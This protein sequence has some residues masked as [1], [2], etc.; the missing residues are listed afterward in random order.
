MGA[1]YQAVDENLGIT[2]AVKENLFLTEEFSRQFQHETN[3]LAGLKH[4][5]LPRVVDYISIPDQ[6]QYLIMDYIE[7]ED[8]RQRIERLKNIPEREVLLIGV[9]ICDALTYLHTRT[10]PVIHRDIKP[11]NIK[12][13]PQGL[14][15]LVDFGLAK[16]MIASQQTNTG[17]RA[18]TPGYSPPEQYGTA[19]T[20]PRT[21]IYSL[22][23]TLYACLTGVIPEDALARAT[24]KTDLTPVREMTPQI[25]RKTASCIEKALEIDPDDRFQT[26]EQFKKA[27]LDAGDINPITGKLTTITPPPESALVN[28]QVPGVDRDSTAGDPM[29]NHRNSKPRSRRRKNPSLWPAAII[30]GFLAIAFSL[31]YSFYPDWLESSLAPLMAVMQDRSSIPTNSPT[32]SATATQPATLEPT[33]AI[34]PIP[35]INPTEPNLPQPSATP[36]GGSGQIAFSSNR[37]GSMQVWLMNVDGSM[38]HSLTNMPDGACKP[39]W[40]PDGKKIAFVSPCTTRRDLYEGAKI[41]ILDVDAKTEPLPLQLPP[42][43]GSDYDPAWSPDGNRIAFTSTRAGN[44]DIYVFNLLDL[45]LQQLTDERNTE[46]YPA[47][48]PTGSQI[49]YT[50]DSV[51]SQVWIMSDT[52]QF[53]SRFSISGEL[54]DVWPTWTPDGSLVLFSQMNST[55]EIPSL[56][57][58]RYEDRNTQKSFRIP[59][60]GQPDV[61]PVAQV[62]ISPDGSWLAFEGWPE[63][64][65]HDIYIM[66]ING[67]NRIRLTSDKDL[68]FGPAWRPLS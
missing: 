27:L 59:T 52:G 22:G 67:T 65:N 34:T 46:K 24:G 39:N 29:I 40:S 37:T 43:P 61:G 53:Q 42:S 30:F 35:I 56:Y 21:D 12:I 49:A 5:S 7:G 14:I 4:P 32:Q 47:W 62:S 36:K 20:D 28:P 26:A 8:L 60:R 9:A 64:M 66:T 2:V 63:G 16:V 50:R 15:S 51:Y 1:V 19:P 31:T 10:P 17:A 38:Q 45:S 55:T 41:Y 18:M 6:G 13:T 58:L 48:S 33:T 68:D 3:I 54:N 25:S 44:P 23:A 57:A 11:G